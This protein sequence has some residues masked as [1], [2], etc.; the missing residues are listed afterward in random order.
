[1][2]YK[3]NVLSIITI[4][5]F[6]SLLNYAQQGEWKT[7]Y[8]GREIN[9]L[10][11]K[12]KYL[13]AGT[14]CGL[15]NINLETDE[16]KLFDK[17][18]TNGQLGK[19]N[20]SYI[21]KNGDVYL[22]SGSGYGWHQF[23][24][25]FK[26][27]FVDN[28]TCATIDK[29]GE[30]WLG[31]RYSGI[32]YSKYDS[33]YNAH[34]FHWLRKSNSPLPSD[35]IRALYFDQYQNLWV[36]CY[37]YDGIPGDKGGLVKYDGTNWTIYDETNS[38]LPTNQMN[39]MVFDKY[40]NIW[41]GTDYYGLFK[42]SKGTWTN[43][44]IAPPS[45]SEFKYSDVTSLAV[46]SL[47]NIWIGTRFTGLFEFDGTTWKVYDAYNSN[48]HS[49]F[50]N[51]V[52]VDYKNRVWVG[53]EIGLFRLEKDSLIEYNTS[54]APL[55]NYQLLKVLPDSKGNIWILNQDYGSPYVANKNTASL[56][57]YDGQNFTVYN[58]YDFSKSLYGSNYMTID[59]NDNIWLPTYDG[60]IKYDGDK[61]K[62]YEF[63]FHT[64]FQPRAICT[65]I[66]NNIWI[67]SY[68]GNIVKFDG[69]KFTAYLASENS[70]PALSI[71]SMMSPG[72]ILYYSYNSDNK[73]YE[74]DVSQSSNRLNVK[75]FET[76]ASSIADVKI[77]P[78]GEMWIASHELGVYYY[79]GSNWT[80]YNTNN[81]GLPTNLARS[82]D[83]DNNGRIIVACDDSFGNTF[84]EGGL[85]FYDGEKWE[86]YKY[87]NSKLGPISTYG[88]IFD[89]RGNIWAYGVNAVTEFNLQS[90]NTEPLNESTVN[91]LSQSFPN[92]SNGSV[93]IKYTIAKQ[94]NV[95][96]RIFD[97]LGKEVKTLVHEIRLKGNYFAY[98][99]GK[100]NF[101]RAVA[102]GVYLYSLITKDEIIT[103]KLVW[104]K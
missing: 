88:A 77:T 60:L 102:S 6:I 80:N 27:Y 7:F 94:S 1:M 13:Y 8:S 71:S 15:V 104:L 96:L 98:W 81:F 52:I 95:D 46:D 25:D 91:S 3:K 72:A 18:N 90:I 61:W 74:I 11:T 73:I 43:Y 55:P 85:A 35:N 42:F 22:A 82:I 64:K 41:I 78:K 89:K 29:F 36:L 99:D 44:K 68:Y 39:A 34:I 84:S 79:N 66:F 38:P 56:T 86:T 4:I 93:F 59:R 47:N 58:I 19:T 28:L 9:S 33:N 62:L 87:S 2:K 100:D 10:V 63:D 30:T 23:D 69:K 103:D 40:G 45:Y 51:S 70:L 12:G 101:G 83:V 67:G 5:F 20:V 75:T 24:S 14:N 16:I 76:P 21:D 65:D 31:T 50:I 26:C 48:L 37:D 49:S 53:T 54:N 97:I 17:F 57:K 32:D 92:P